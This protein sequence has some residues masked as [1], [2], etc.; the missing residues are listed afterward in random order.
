MSFRS[1]IACAAVVVASL[2]AGAALAQQT[3]EQIFASRCKA[4]HEPYRAEKND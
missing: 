1:W 3:G 4:C 2:T